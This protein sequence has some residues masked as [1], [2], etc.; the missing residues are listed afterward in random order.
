MDSDSDSNCVPNWNQVV[1]ILSFCH[2]MKLSFDSRN[3][4]GLLSDVIPFF[5]VYMQCFPFHC[6]TYYYIV[7]WV[8]HRAN[9]II[10][11]DSSFRTIFLF[12]NGQ[13]AEEEEIIQSDDQLVKARRMDERCLD[14]KHAWPLAVEL[15]LLLDRPKTYF[16]WESS[17][18]DCIATC[19]MRRTP[20]TAVL[21][22]P[23]SI[24]TI[25][26]LT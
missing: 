14:C 2:Q 13:E 19:C 17:S 15:M 9:I 25:L 23:V 7:I 1:Q 24:P 21:P 11:H 3:H 22:H 12:N 4:L 18:M 6:L 10:F 5:M 26:N 16:Y 20:L 8:R